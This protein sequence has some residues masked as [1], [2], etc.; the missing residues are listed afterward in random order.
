MQKKD[1]SP[2]WF[3]PREGDPAVYPLEIVGRGIRKDVSGEMRKVFTRQP[4]ISVSCCPFSLSLF[5]FLLS[6]GEPYASTLWR[7]I[8]I[9]PSDGVGCPRHPQR[10]QHRI[11]CRGAVERRNPCHS[12]VCMRIKP[13][14]IAVSANDVLRLLYIHHGCWQHPVAFILSSSG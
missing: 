12:R 6:R 4:L 1:R 14:A 7:R 13:A 3:S 11:P 9:H 2:V 8:T 5:N 10:A